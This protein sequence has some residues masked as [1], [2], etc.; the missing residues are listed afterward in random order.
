MQ[1]Q[2]N[3]SPNCPSS[4]QKNATS[5]V[6]VVKGKTILSGVKPEVVAKNELVCKKKNSPQAFDFVG[7]AG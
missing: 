4:V 6:T 7:I 5:I 3:T 1:L 2:E